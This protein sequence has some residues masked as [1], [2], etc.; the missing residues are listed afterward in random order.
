MHQMKESEKESK[1]KSTSIEMESLLQSTRSTPD[2]VVIEMG[3]LPQSTGNIS[4]PDDVVI[5]MP[6]AFGEFQSVLVP[7]LHQEIE[8]ALETMEK[9]LDTLIQQNDRFHADPPKISDNKVKK[10]KG[11]KE[12]TAA[13]IKAN[14]YTHFDLSV[15]K[16][17][18]LTREVLQESLQK[19]L[20]SLKSEIR[21]H[22]PLYSSDSSRKLEK[23]NSDIEKLE[24]FLNSSDIALDLEVRKSN[25]KLTWKEYSKAVIQGKEHMRAVALRSFAQSLISAGS[26]SGAQ[27][28]A[29]S[30][31]E[32]AFNAMVSQLTERQANE[33]VE[34][35]LD[36]PIQ[37]RNP[38]ITATN[39]PEI[40]A[41]NSPEITTA[42][43]Q[44]IVS[45]EAL[46]NVTNAIA[47]SDP[48]KFSKDLCENLLDHLQSLEELPDT[49]DELKAVAV[50]FLNGEIE[51]LGNERSFSHNFI[52]TM[53]NCVDFSSE[54]NRINKPDSPYY[55]ATELDYATIVGGDIAIAIVKGCILP[56]CDSLYEKSKDIR[57][58]EKITSQKKKMSKFKKFRREAS[59]SMSNQFKGTITVLGLILL[60]KAASGKLTFEQAGKDITFNALSLATVGTIDGVRSLCSCGETTSQVTKATLRTIVGRGVPQVLKSYFSRSKEFGATGVAVT[61][62][63]AG[64]LLGGALKEINGALW[65]RSANRPDGWMNSWAGKAAVHEKALFKALKKRAGSG[66]TVP[67][68]LKAV[69]KVN[70]HIAKSNTYLNQVD[71]TLTEVTTIPSVS[72]NL[73]SGYGAGSLNS[74]N[75][76]TGATNV[77]AGATNVT[78]GATNVTAGATNV[79]AG[80]AS[81]ITGATNVTARATNVSLGAINPAF[82]HTTIQSLREQ[83][84]KLD[85]EIEKIQ[86]SRKDPKI[87][88]EQKKSLKQQEKSL[89]SRRTEIRQQRDILSPPTTS[90]TDNI[91]TTAEVHPIRKFD[92]TKFKSSSITPNPNGARPK[93]GPK[94]GPKQGP[95]QS[96]KQGPK[97]GTTRL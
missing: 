49:V 30:L 93:K 68:F 20:D 35:F 95:K 41:T 42:S 70:D 76:V 63:L 94:K 46:V 82:Q 87:T 32:L 43:L 64:V 47:T 15:E 2:D 86:K 80:A 17:K 60:L 36:G 37:D 53:Q 6:E 4:A 85:T 65:Q 51:R 16:R 24:E 88:E 92:A 71:P 55:D 12:K 25:G 75:P 3:S 19:D 26:G 27:V 81:G 9:K 67:N 52:K 38:E 23:L 14:D 78:A 62:D 39:S 58:S 89:E 72:Q 11:F 59:D 18:L 73:L 77:T 22:L 50:S 1:E 96:P 10:K 21:S 66:T 8:A 56:L 48:A 83:Q 44:S 84:Q 13:F 74:S 69:N 97:T 40:T 61:T 5:E 29:A 31:K 34:D 57:E 54:I 7:S 79:T 45:D 33:V 90:N 28:L 91:V